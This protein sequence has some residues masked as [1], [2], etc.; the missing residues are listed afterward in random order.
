MSSKIKVLLAGLLVIVGLSV[1]GII[2]SYNLLTGSTKPSSPDKVAQKD[3][4]TDKIAANTYLGDINISG[5]DRNGLIELLSKPETINVFIPDAFN[6]TGAEKEQQNAIA[7]SERELLHEQEIL[8]TEGEDAQAAAAAFDPKLKDMSSAEIHEL[9]LEISK[10]F[11]IETPNVELNFDADSIY[12][13]AMTG[14]A[15]A[16]TQDEAKSFIEE[17]GGSRKIKPVYTYSESALKSEIERLASFVKLEPSRAVATG[18][19]L[20]TKKFVLKAG[21]PGRRLKNDDLEKTLIEKIK[22][23]D[24]TSE[25]A[26][27]FE[28]TDDKES[29]EQVQNKLGFVSEATTYVPYYSEGRNGNLRVGSERIDGQI[30]QPHSNFSLLE[31]LGEMSG[32]NGY[33]PAAVE[34][35]GKSEIGYG[36]G[37]CQVSSTLFQAAAKANLNFIEHHN[38]GLES[39]YCKPGTD[40]MIEDW[41]DLIIENPTDYPYAIVTEYNDEYLTYSIYGPANPDNATIELA[42][43]HLGWVEPGED[44]EVEDDSLPVGTRE[45]VRS[46]VVGQRTRTYRIYYVDGEEVDHKELFESY[47]IAYPAKYRVGT[48]KS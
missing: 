40:A 34:V 11:L 42:V 1:V 43:E 47:Y 15:K 6:L 28:N 30:I 37:L 12:E 29:L 41:A 27:P 32:E 33:F 17:K 16:F 8:N 44:I 3:T 9:A 7:E 45:L 22:A 10:N 2:Y 23:G 25:I 20:E 36:G 21:E 35:D 39:A 48:K 38:H 46:P 26:L 31:H 5:L 19:D 13:L 14:K 18:F 24:V 4:Q